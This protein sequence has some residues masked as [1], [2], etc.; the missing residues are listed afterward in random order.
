[1]KYESRT[2][3]KTR[4]IVV[5]ESLTTELRYSPATTHCLSRRNSTYAYLQTSSSQLSGTSAAAEDNVCGAVGGGAG[6][7]LDCA[8]GTLAAG[9]R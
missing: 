1:M 8:R 9:G 6:D 7:A 5:Q 4:N 2:F 3:C